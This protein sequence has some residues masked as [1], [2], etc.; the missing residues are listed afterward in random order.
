MEG[1]IEYKGGIYG[2][3]KDQRLRKADLFILTSRYEGM[4]MGILEALSYGIPCI[5]TPGTN[6]ADEISESN[7]GWV[8][9]FNA[10]QIAETIKNAVEEYSNDP[11][12]FIANA[13]NLSKKYDWEKIASDS[14]S[15]YQ[16]VL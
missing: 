7:A 16:L 1:L 13:Y 6:M 14:V 4:P 3:D 5:V 10:Q 9:S 15:S 2:D 12:T 8:S 11:K